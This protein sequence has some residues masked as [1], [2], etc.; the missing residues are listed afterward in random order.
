MQDGD[1]ITRE[2]Y[3]EYLA[4]GKLPWED[5]KRGNKYH[6]K[7]QEVGGIIFDSTKEA[8]RYQELL[9]LQRLGLVTDIR[10]QVSY[11]LIPMQ[12]D[13][14]GK[15]IERA[16]T[17]KADF[18]YRR[19]DTNEEVVEDAKGMRP[20]TYIIKRKLMLYR[21]GIRISEV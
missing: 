6:A 14:N 13:S 16:V 8:N 3:N 21:Y 15:L 1:I 19:L 9:M 11:E 20:Q 5:K 7:R 10:R 18:V 2:E 4:T 17:Y 12:K